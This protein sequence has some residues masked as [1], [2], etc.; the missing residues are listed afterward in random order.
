MDIRV[1]DVFKK[2]IFSD[3]DLIFILVDITFMLWN[4]A[5]SYHLWPKF[6]LAADWSSVAITVFGHQGALTSW[7]FNCKLS[8][9]GQTVGHNSLKKRI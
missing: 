1:R 4:L 5:S 8:Q 3:G 7:F 9:S 6:I 2:Y